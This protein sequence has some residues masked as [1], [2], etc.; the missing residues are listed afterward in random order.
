MSLK[1]AKL[2]IVTS[3]SI[4]VLCSCQTSNICKTSQPEYTAVI[5]EKKV[6]FKIPIDCSAKYA[7]F[8]QS[9]PDTELEY[10]CS[11]FLENYKLGFSLFNYPGS[12]EEEG[13]INKLL[14]AGQNS[15]WRVFDKGKR[16]D[17]VMGAKINVT[18]QKPN[19][20]ISVTDPK[21]FKLITSDHPRSF[22]VVVTGFKPESKGDT[23][24]PITYTK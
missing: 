17:I 20:L 24:L 12:K 14:K 3:I 23:S 15:V 4:L 6:E 10:D 19:L 22:R 7:W 21:I 8:R 5:S 11:V 18:Y 9:T 16:G 1:L 13:S 2:F